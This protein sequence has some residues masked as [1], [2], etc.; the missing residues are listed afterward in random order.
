MWVQALI[1]VGTGKS[2]C[3]SKPILWSREAKLH[4]P[5]SIGVHVPSVSVSGL[6]DGAAYAAYFK[7]VEDVGLDAVWV[8][9]RIFHPAHLADSL[10]LL[11]WAAAA[12][13]RIQLGTAVT[14]LNLRHAPVL[15]RQIATLQHLSGGRVTLG[16]SIGGRPEE[17][18][19]LG[20]PMVRRVGVFRESLGVLRSL[21]TGE[22]VNI[23][24][25]Y[26]SLTDAIVRPAADIPI[27]I[28][29]IAENAIERAGE[30]G[31]GWI[32]GPFGGVEE[33]RQGWRIAQAAAKAANKNLEDLTAG[34]LIYIAIDNNKEK[35][36]EDIT[37]F[38]HGYYGPDF[39]MEKHAIYGSS[40]EVADRLKALAEAGLTHF[41][42][43]LPSLNV[44]QLQRLAEEVAP[45][46]R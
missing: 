26:F 22:V 5:V 19:A 21:L 27:L 46:L 35:A 40:S 45:V 10:T 13:T 44:T 15:A 11:T 12:T 33:F 14:V 39:G 34:R 36:R 3:R 20:V 29:G 6:A 37:A 41:M 31:D 28:G 42:L 1:P 38:L 18:Q 32:M 7:L 16:V 4:K 25:T 43:G 24:G 2:I 8:E 9:D 30:L 17:Y 23:D